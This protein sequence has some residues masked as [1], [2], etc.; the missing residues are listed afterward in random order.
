[1]RDRT[2]MHSKGIGDLTELFDVCVC[3]RARARKFEELTNMICTSR[4]YFLILFDGK[5][6]RVT[7]VQR[8]QNFSVYI[9]MP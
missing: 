2:K 4:S 5:L 9:S 6:S 7:L 1:M 8:T 3:A